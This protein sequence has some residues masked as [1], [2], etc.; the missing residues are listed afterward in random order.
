[1]SKIEKNCTTWTPCEDIFENFRSK[2]Y[3]IMVLNC[4]LN[5]NVDHRYLV[6][7]WTH[8]KIRVTVDGGTSRWLNWLQ[9]HECED[10]YIFSPNLITGD[11][12]SLSEEVLDYFVERNSKIIKTPNQHETDFTKALKEMHTHCQNEGIEIDMVFVLGDTSGRFDQIIA[13][14]NTMYKALSFMSTIKIFQIATNSLTFLLSPGNHRI[15]IPKTLRDK[16]G[17]CALIPLGAPCIAS[18]TGLKWNL[19]KT[20]LEFGGMV[21]T[22]NTYSDE[23]FATISTDGFL[24]WSMG[25]EAIL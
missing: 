14:I 13:N 3:A 9:A 16:E 18:T 25:I 2:D 6:N 15:S 20:Q 11:L 8:A 12:D 21:S 5:L 10:S 1:M 22:S 24:T 23:A 17:W 4:Q 7:L 19:D